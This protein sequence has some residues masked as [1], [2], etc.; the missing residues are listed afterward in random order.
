M[1]I[2]HIASLRLVNLERRMCTM[3]LMHSAA[4]AT[5]AVADDVGYNSLHAVQAGWP[6]VSS[7]PNAT[8]NGLDRK[9]DANP[10]I[11]VT[12]DTA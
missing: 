2:E 5:V 1:H 10:R 4:I 9:K 6:D 3:I 8:C 12:R 11:L 7:Q